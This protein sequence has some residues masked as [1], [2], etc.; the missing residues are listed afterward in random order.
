M[1]NDTIGK[2]CN[3][4]RLFLMDRGHYTSHETATTSSKRRNIAFLNFLFLAKTVFCIP[5]LQR[6][7]QNFQVLL[8][9]LLLLI[10]YTT[11]VYS[12]KTTIC[13]TYRTKALYIGICTRNE[14]ILLHKM[15]SCAYFGISVSDLSVLFSFRQISTQV[16][17]FVIG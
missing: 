7:F 16:L 2:F 10:I 14:I 6:C 15:F 9:Y 8:N 11:K 5:S 4:L 3:L 13:F 1:L 12:D 17:V